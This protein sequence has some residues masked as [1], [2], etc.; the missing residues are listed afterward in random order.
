MT[1][2]IVFCTAPASPTDLMLKVFVLSPTK[3]F[4]FTLFMALRELLTCTPAD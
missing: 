4:W 3:L 1:A 2:V